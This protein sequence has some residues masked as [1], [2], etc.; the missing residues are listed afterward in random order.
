MAPFI[1]SAASVSA[2]SPVHSCFHTLR[3]PSPAEQLHTVRVSRHLTRHRE[4]TKAVWPFS[5]RTRRGAME[6][7][8]E[9]APPA[10]FCAGK[11]KHM[12]QFNN[13]Q[14]PAPPAV[15]CA[16]NGTIQQPHTQP[17]HTQNEREAVVTADLATK[18]ADPRLRC[19]GLGP[20]PTSRT[21][22]VP[23]T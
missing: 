12:V 8:Q 3:V 6:P 23:S 22:W 5:R 16:G 18:V 10:V 13:H 11:Q 20:P 17:S 1:T 19:F 15:F 4:F 7:V 9:P 14:E 2:L 21:P